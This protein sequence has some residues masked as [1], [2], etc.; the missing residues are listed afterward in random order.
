M[1]PFV[2][3]SFVQFW[4]L[5]S[6]VWLYIGWIPD[7]LLSNK[8]VG[9]FCHP[10]VSDL[11]EQCTLFTDIFEYSSLS[12]LHNESCIIIK[13]LA[14][15]EPTWLTQSV[16]Q[17]LALAYF[18]SCCVLCFIDLAVLC[19]E[20]SVCLYALFLNQSWKQKKNFSV[21]QIF[22]NKLFYMERKT[23][24]L[25]G[26][27]WIF[28]ARG[29]FED[30]PCWHKAKSGTTE[31]IQYKSIRD[32]LKLYIWLF[33]EA[34]SPKA[35]CY[36]GSQCFPLPYMKSQKTWHLNPSIWNQINVS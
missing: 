35:M 33:T 26:Q 21:C 30:C 4:N 18:E 16:A 9:L 15:V 14:T 8:S 25:S 2:E 22:L 34:H 20:M 3:W 32:V 7:A 31:L 5:K 28:T 11:R 29:S 6:F 17:S 36:L 12:H 27:F 24:V 10:S 13:T 23:A 1:S 19:H